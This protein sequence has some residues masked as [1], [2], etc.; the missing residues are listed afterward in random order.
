MIKLEGIFPPI[1]TP[2]GTDGE[3]STHK[4]RSNIE[5][6]NRTGLAGY[7]P[8]GSTGE[9][10]LLTKDEKLKIWETVRE[11]AAPGKLLIAGTAAESVRDTIAL[12]NAAA[13]RG[14]QVALVRTPHYYKALMTRADAQLTYFRMVADSAKIPIVIYNF[15]QCT[16]VDVPVEVIAQLSEHPNILGIK[17]SS[18]NIEKVE[19]LVSE[20]REGFQVLVGSAQTLYPSLCVGAVGGILAFACSAPCAALSIYE[21][22]R[23]RDHEAAIERQRRVIR[24]AMAVT[25][26]HGIPGN[27]HAMDL[28][29]YYGGPVRPPLLPLSAEAKKDVEEAFRDIKG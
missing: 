20:T 29:G 8:T 25:T 11:A 10:V 12:T 2:F 6:W 24:A 28:N 21:A 1:T 16:G 3:V 4:L 23:T 15:P 9:S 22:H 13:E 27:K 5:K 19:R 17:E 7:V 26:K 14:F 18:G